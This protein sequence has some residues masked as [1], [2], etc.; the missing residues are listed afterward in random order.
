MLLD[1]RQ[2]LRLLAAASASAFTPRP[3]VADYDPHDDIRIVV[4]FPAGGPLDIA[5][6]LVAPIIAARLGVAVQVANRVGDSGNDATRAVIRSR[7]DGRTLLLCGPVNTINATLFQGLDF[8]FVADTVPVAGIASVPLIVETHPD[9]PVASISD[10][11][12]FARSAPGR[13]RVAYAGRGTP[14]HVAIALFQAKAGINFELRPYPGSAQALADLLEGRADVMFDPAPSSMPHIRAGRLKA[15]ATTGAER[16]AFLPDLP[17]V[18]ETIPG[19]E[20]G[21]WF[22]LVAPKLT[23]DAVVVPIHAAVSEAQR[24]PAFLAL[25]RNLGASPLAFSS[26]EL[27]RFIADETRR[28]SAVT[29]AMNNH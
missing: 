5:A 24:D 23:P 21:S 20:A 22:G 4:G 18:S 11:V 14:Q 29:P 2:A 19:Y 9:L 27:A 10:L 6:R 1:R 26:T 28:Y 15:L 12:S 3:S 7:P 25:L 16:S 8:D 13:V 17:T